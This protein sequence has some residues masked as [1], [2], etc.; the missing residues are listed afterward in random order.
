L[1]DFSI[2]TTAQFIDIATEQDGGTVGHGLQSHTS[3]IRAVRVN[4]PTTSKP[5]IFI[6]TPGFDDTFK[7]DTEILTMIA[8]WL[9]KMWVLYMG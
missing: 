8:E 6:D 4:H 7:S 9:V 2:L 3:I 5:V 1:N